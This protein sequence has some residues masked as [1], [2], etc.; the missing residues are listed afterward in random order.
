MAARRFGLSVLCALLCTVVSEQDIIMLVGNPGVGKSTLL[1]SLLEEVRF[2]SG[3]SK[4]S[5][6]TQEHAVHD[7]T[8][9]GRSVKLVD[10]PGL[11]DVETREQCAKEISKGLKLEG[12]YKLIMIVKEEDGRVVEQDKTTLKLILDAI[13][14][15]KDNEFGLVVNKISEEMMI[16]YRTDPSWKEELV[17]KLFAGLPKKTE[18]IRLLQEEKKLRSKHNATLDS[19]DDGFLQVQDLIKSILP[20]FIRKADV[21]DVKVSEWEKESKELKG[22]I[23]AL[24]KDKR[25]L[26]AE[27]QSNRGLLENMKNNEAKTQKAIEDLRKQNEE[28]KKKSSGGGFGKIIGSLFGPVGT[29]IGA[30]VDGDL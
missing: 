20:P 25:K 2:P 11:A 19:I 27:I 30:A 7:V 4:G 23:A 14:T 1:N 22:Q 5:G 28:L 21:E 13:P 12:R 26:D 18:H 24:N 9:G 29:L 17:T 6:M 8:I 3:P 16:N 15:I 10:S